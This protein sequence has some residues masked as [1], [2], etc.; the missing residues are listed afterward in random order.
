[1]PGWQNQPTDLR[2]SRRRSERSL[3]II[4]IAALLVV[5]SVAIGLVY[6]WSA[7]LSGLICLLPGAGGLSLLW[8]LLR[9][10]ERWLDHSDR[11]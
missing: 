6:G 7:I 3:V 4:V 8:I 10:I 11:L 9:L 5:G 1:M 2:G